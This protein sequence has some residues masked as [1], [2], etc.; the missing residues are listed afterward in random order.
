MKTP[1]SPITAQ[2]PSGK[3]KQAKNKPSKNVTLCPRMKRQT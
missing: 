1:K 3:T 2:Q